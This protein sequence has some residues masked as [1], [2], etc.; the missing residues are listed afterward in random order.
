MTQKMEDEEASMEDIIDKREELMVSP[1]GSSPTRR[2]AY[3]IKPCASSIHGCDLL[4]PFTSNH[5]NVAQEVRYHGWRM[6]HKKWKTWVQNMQLRYGHIWIKAGIHHAIKAST[7]EI[8]RNDELILALAQRWCSKTNTFI[9]PWGEATLT[10]EDMKACWGYSVMGGSVSSPLETT[11]EKEIEAKLIALRS[12]F[13]KSRAKKATQ[14]QWMKH[15]MDNESQLE[16]EGFLSM[17]LSRFVFP[18]ISEDTI[19]KSVF[20]IAVHLA[21]GTRIALAPAVLA[22]IYRDLSLL[23]KS[24][25]SAATMKLR[26]TLWAPFQLVQVWA[27]ERFPALQPN[28]CPVRQGQP[29]MAKWDRVKMLKKNNLNLILDDAGSRNGFLWRPYQNSP[30]LY[31]Y[32]EKDMWM[33]DNPCFDDELQ[34]FS[35]CLRVS[36]LV[37][38]GCIENYRPNR[39]AMQFGMDQ[40]IPGVVDPSNKD[41]WMSYSQPIMDINLCPA[42]CSSQPKV[43]SR[44]YNWW[45]QLNS[46]KEGDTM[47]GH[48]HCLISKN[49]S[50][51]LSPAL[52]RE[53]KCDLSFGPLPDFT[54]KFGT[55]QVGN[56]GDNSEDIVADMQGEIVSVVPFNLENRILKLETVIAKHKEAKFG[57]KG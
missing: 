6:P 39:V 53:V 35:R 25:R 49:S 28:P 7:Y 22:S 23:S 19:L 9:F 2:I 27:L 29:I 33:C 24:V 17:W 1:G 5:A 52:T 11:E 3:F 36:E 45:K 56:S 18:A 48:D 15:F 42:L 57:S 20:S 14:T 37:G 26:V 34:A 50:Q 43:T 16:H 31:L 12:M 13:I 47:K 41:P 55:C 54:C 32:N 44:Y 4:P 21:R 51:H 46:G 8:N 30:P 40:D 10:L 38:M